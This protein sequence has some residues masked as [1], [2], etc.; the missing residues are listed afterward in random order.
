MQMAQAEAAKKQKVTEHVNRFDGLIHRDNGELIDPVDGH[1]VII[2]T[3]LIE[4]EEE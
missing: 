3:D 1:K 2:D 4:V